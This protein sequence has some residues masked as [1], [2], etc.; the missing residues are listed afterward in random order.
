[1]T[2]M[3]V[4]ATLRSEPLDRET[5]AKSEDVIVTCILFFTRQPLKMSLLFS[6]P[7]DPPS[8]P[9]LGISPPKLPLLLKSYVEA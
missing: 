8:S 6:T 9:S 3:N 7:F 5:H 2:S 1:M 4:P